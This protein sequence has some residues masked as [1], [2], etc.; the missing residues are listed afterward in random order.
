MQFSEN[1]WAVTREL[2]GFGNILAVFGEVLGEIFEQYLPQQ[3]QFLERFW[4]VSR[5]L[6]GNCWAVFGKNLGSFKRT[7]GLWRN[8]GQFLDHVWAILGE[9]FGNFWRT[10]WQFLEKF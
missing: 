2:L 7:F 10:L 8:F 3:G 6:L 5:E 4:A 1:I 9:L